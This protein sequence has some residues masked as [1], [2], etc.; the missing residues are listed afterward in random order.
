MKKLFEPITKSLTGRTI[1]VDLD[2]MN[3]IRIMP[4]LF[5]NPIE[6]AILSW[7]LQRVKGDY[8][9]IGVNQGATALNICRNNPFKT[10]Y[11]VDMVHDITMHKNQSIEQPTEETAGIY[12][13]DEPNFE[14]ILENSWHVEIPEDVGMIFLDADHTYRG[15]KNDME[16]I[17][18][19]VHSCTLILLHDYHNELHPEYIGV[20]EYVDK[21]L[22]GRFDLYE[23]ENTWLI[24]MIT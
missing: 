16:N 13:K 11:G 23:F 14:L 4:G 10:I 9:E 6:I 21:E 2:K 22:S 15:V 19:Q 17:L 24:G 8:M 7:A 18:K 20:K 12:C 5:C 1:E 3:D